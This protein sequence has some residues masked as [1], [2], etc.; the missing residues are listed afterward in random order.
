MLAGDRQTILEIKTVTLLSDHLVTKIP[1]LEY[2]GAGWVRSAWPSQQYPKYF[3]TTAFSLSRLWQTV[4]F[5]STG[6]APMSTGP[7]KQMRN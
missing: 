1:A 3:L 7:Y 5:S 6:A 2:L 4:L